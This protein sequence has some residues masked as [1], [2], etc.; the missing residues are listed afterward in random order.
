MTKQE[1]T[2]IIIAVLL[3]ALTGCVGGGSPDSS[4]LPE[5]SAKLPVPVVE[6]TAGIKEP[7]GEGTKVPRDTAGTQG[8]V[9]S[10]DGDSIDTANTVT[11]NS[12]TTTDTPAVSDNAADYVV[13]FSGRLR[14]NS[15][16]PPVDPIVTAP[17]IGSR[18]ALTRSLL[19]GDFTAGYGPWLESQFTSY[20]MGVFYGFGAPAFKNHVGILGVDHPN[21]T[22][23]GENICLLPGEEPYR[24]ITTS[25]P[26]LLNASYRGTVAGQTSSNEYIVGGIG[27]GFRNHTGTVCSDCYDVTVDFT[28]NLPIY[29]MSSV[30][31]STD[32][33]AF[34]VSQC[35]V[36]TGCYQTLSATFYRPQVGGDV[37]M[38]GRVRGS[39][40]DG[41][42]A[43]RET[44]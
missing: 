13:N 25:R 5:L 44:N 43:A 4:E 38:G 10:T 29:D 37:T 33:G 8:V 36:G 31:R 20:G 6:D 32:K 2:I 26:N 16:P 30:I 18:T 15:P 24:S 22:V 12:T 41:L 42:F 35:E 19:D 14:P 34:S 27:M 28:D 23:D 3:L 17:N 40:F 11:A 21:C 7:S 1:M 9:G 39:D